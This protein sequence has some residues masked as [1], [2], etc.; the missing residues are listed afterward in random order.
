MLRR[1]NFRF[2]CFHGKPVAEK[3]ESEANIQ[4]V[5]FLNK[6]LRIVRSKTNISMINLFGYEIPLEQ[7]NSRGKCVDLMGYDKEYNLFLIELKKDKTSEK[8][9][10]IIEQI[11][12]YADSVKVIREAIEAEFEKTFFFK[13]KFSL[14]IKKVILAPREFYKLRSKKELTDATIEYAFI[15]KNLVK[16]KLNGKAIDV[17]IWKRNATGR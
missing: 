7:G 8:M 17:H 3:I 4:R 1:E 11:N 15:G 14:M 2:G 6:Q 16:H 10:K 9:S 5:L 13:I 12:G